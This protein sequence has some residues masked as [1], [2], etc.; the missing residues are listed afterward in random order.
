M[1]T[2]QVKFIPLDKGKF[3]TLN[4]TER[5]VIINNGVI[6]L[7]LAITDGVAAQ[8]FVT[9]GSPAIMEYIVDS[10][11]EKLDI[12]Q[13]TAQAIIQYVE[14]LTGKPAEHF[15]LSKIVKRLDT[16]G[17]II[18]DKNDKEAAYEQG[19]LLDKNWQNARLVSTEGLGHQRILRDARVIEQIVD[20]VS[21]AGEIERVAS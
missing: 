10:F 1:T 20:F 16:D 3:F 6:A 15:S 9:I 5:F 17:L 19:L 4:K 12:N 2:G 8:K 13:S 14:Q 7:A 18:H 11:R 21:S